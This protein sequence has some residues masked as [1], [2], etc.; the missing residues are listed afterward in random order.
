[1]MSEF[2]LVAAFVFVGLSLL[3]LLAKLDAELAALRAILERVRQD[4]T[5]LPPE[6]GSLALLPARQSVRQSHINSEAGTPRLY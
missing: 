4:L 3:L 1:M 6:A 5:A 2:L